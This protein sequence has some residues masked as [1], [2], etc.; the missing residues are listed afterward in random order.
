[1][2]KESTKQFCNEHSGIKVKE[3]AKHGVEFVV[4]TVHIEE[5]DKQKNIRRQYTNNIYPD[6]LTM[7]QQ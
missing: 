7:Q 5:N 6:L 2:Y 3:I 1:M 4:H